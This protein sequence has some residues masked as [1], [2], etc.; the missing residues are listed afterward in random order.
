MKKL[1]MFL[2]CSVFLFGADMQMVDVNFDLSKAQEVKFIEDNPAQ[3]T[4]KIPLD[5]DEP[6]VGENTAKGK[7]K[8]TS[9]KLVCRVKDKT[10]LLDKGYYSSKIVQSGKSVAII[11]FNG[12][13]K[14]KLMKI[15]RADCWIEYFT[16]SGYEIVYKMGL[17]DIMEPSSN[18][19]TNDFFY[20]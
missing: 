19:L 7:I 9:Q 8:S 16:E 6:P 4:I 5:L 15:S 11:K 20:F 13:P 10:K 17:S 18:A 12:I 3:I 2:V 14:E 1:V